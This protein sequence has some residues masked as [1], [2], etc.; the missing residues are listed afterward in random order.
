MK[1]KE[2]ADH[3]R[4]KK[5]VRFFFAY[6][7]TTTLLMPVFAVTPPVP[8]PYVAPPT[9]PSSIT[10]GQ[11][12]EI[13][14]EANNIGGKSEDGAIVISFPSMTGTG[15]KAYVE[16]AAADTD[17]IYV[18]QEKGELIWH[19][20][21]LQLYAAY[22]K[23]EWHE[24]GWGT[25]E[26]NYLR[27]RVKPKASGDFYFYVRSSMGQ[28]NTYYNFPTSSS[29]KDQQGWE[30]SKYK[31]TVNPPPDTT[32]PTIGVFSVAPASLVEGN[33]FTISYTVSDSGGSGLKQ[34]ELWRAPDNGSNAPGFWGVIPV[35]A[36]L[37]SG[38]GPV[39]GSFSDAP[40]PAGVY[41]YGIHVL[42]NKDNRST[43]AEFGLGPKKVTVTPPVPS[44]YV[45]PP[46]YPSSIT[47]GQS[48]EI[49]VEANNI[50]GKS[51]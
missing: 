36:N 39:S 45:A 18:E 3:P 20:N 38:N 19:R 43:E 8:S 48:A 13:Y 46:T 31:I 5:I 49:Y 14:V 41:W 34:V 10:L 50:G 9:Y 1:T 23:V 44:P 24:P 42:D 21:A 35:K 6:A 28:N 4:V 37:H 2:S 33:A 51:E 40:S 26:K 16:M 47:L 25:A 32:P 22:L 12:A 17:G 11:S 7:F 30:V 27:I 15:D 29:D